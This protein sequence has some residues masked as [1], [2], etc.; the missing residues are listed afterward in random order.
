MIDNEWKLNESNEGSLFT[1]TALDNLIAPLPVSV[2]DSLITFGVVEG[3]AELHAFLSQVLS[4]Y[5]DSV[6]AQDATSTANGIKPEACELC[7]R[8]WIPLTQHHLVPRAIVTKAVR[9]GWVDDRER[10]NI[11]WLCRAC[12]NFVHRVASHEE[13]ARDGRTIQ[14]LLERDDVRKWVGWIGRARRMP[15]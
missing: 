13:L 5:V 3:Q 15:R 10:S 1:R 14:R 12:H 9:R 4:D 11:A 8:P 2:A 7:E 6:A